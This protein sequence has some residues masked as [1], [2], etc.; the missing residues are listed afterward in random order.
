M[1]LAERFKFLFCRHG[2]FAARYLLVGGMN[3]VVG[4]SLFPALQ[5]LLGPLGIHYL[6]TLCVSQLICVSLSFFMLRYW[7][8]RVQNT[9]FVQ[10]LLHSSFYWTY[11][12]INL[13]T[14]PLVVD[15]TKGDPRVIQFFLSLIAM[16]LAFIW[17]KRFVFKNSRGES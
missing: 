7:V 14:L 13:V 12:L 16:T 3:T 5:T 10:Y 2:R 9:S 4:L 8:F 17:Q 6:I 1:T 15:T 11:F